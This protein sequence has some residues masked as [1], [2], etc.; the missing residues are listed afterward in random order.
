[1]DITKLLVDP[2]KEQAGVWT[3]YD[4]TSSLLIGSITSRRY[5]DAY[6]SELDSARIKLRKIS[7]EQAE[8]IQIKVLAKAVLLNWKGVKKGEAEYPYSQENAEYI[9]TNCPQVREFV[10]QAAA[11]IENFKAETVEEAKAQ[12][13][14]A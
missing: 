9:L 1:M 14:E 10:L 12:T 8:K 4:E 13:G 2:A 7:N 6:Q 5:K 11:N 3:D